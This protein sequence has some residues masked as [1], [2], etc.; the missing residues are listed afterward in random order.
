MP[1][2]ASQQRIAE[3]ERVIGRQQLNLDF[4]RQ[5]L[6]ALDGMPAQG[7]HRPVSRKSSKRSAPRRHGGGNSILQD[8]QS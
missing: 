1:G 8:F 4:F 6:R 3:L 5:A 7:K 2:K